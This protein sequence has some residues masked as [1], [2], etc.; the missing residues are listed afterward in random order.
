[1]HRLNGCRPKYSKYKT[2]HN[3]IE[4]IL[5]EAI[6]STT[7]QRLVIRRS[8]QVRMT[9]AA[10]LSERNQRLMPD[11]WYF[12]R[13][14]N[15]IQVI[16]ITVPY[17]SVDDDGRSK[18]AIRRE[19]KIRKYEDLV[20]EIRNRWEIAAH[21][22]IVVVSSLGTVPKDTKRELLSL[23]GGDTKLVNEISRSL[24]LAAVRESALIYWGID[25]TQQRA[26]NHEVNPAQD[27]DGENPTDQDE[28]VD[29]NLIARLFES[30][31]E[32]DTDGSATPEHVSEHDDAHINQDDERIIM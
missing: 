20:T 9:G 18:V 25:P 10:A 17:D 15:C 1:M 28:D 2:R 24:A 27:D 3:A 26:D 29:P 12:D 30:P 6:R 22:H 19:E 21:L 32:H 13:V 16:E 11:L 7:N 31:T 5:I 4:K 23:L 8:T 14:K